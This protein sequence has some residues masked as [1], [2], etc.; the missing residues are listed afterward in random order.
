LGVDQFQALRGGPGSDFL[1]SDN[2]G[3]IRRGSRDRTAIEDTP[4]T[5]KGSYAFV[6]SPDGRFIARGADGISASPGSNLI[7]VV[8]LLTGDVR[9]ALAGGALLA[10]SPGGN[11]VAFR[12]YGQPSDTIAV[13]TVS[14]RL[15]R[16][17]TFGSDRSPKIHQAAW[18]GDTLLALVQDNLLGEAPLRE[19]APDIGRVTV[20]GNVPAGIYVDIA[21]VAWAP[22]AHRAAAITSTHCYLIKSACVLTYSVSVLQGGVA[23]RVAKFLSTQLPTDMSMSPD[24]RWLV[25]AG[26]S[27]MLKALP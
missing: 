3:K 6:V 14:T 18:V 11:E 4:A 15:V 8:D 12:L 21:T 7:Q 2:D 10:V 17:F 25:Y 1:F 16:K 23:T 19:F 27:F 9:Q 26:N 13:V 24:G 22:T 5:S 20:L